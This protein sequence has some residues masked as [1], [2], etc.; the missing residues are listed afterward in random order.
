MIQKLENKA[1]IIS[2]ANFLSMP[3]IRIPEYQRPYKWDEKNVTQLIEDIHFFRHQKGYRFG[4]IV[5]HVNEL[6]ENNQTVVY[7]DIVDGQ[8]RYTTLRLLLYALHQLVNNSNKFQASTLDLISSLK[9][10]LDGIELNYK[11]KSSIENIHRNYQLIKRSIQHFDDDTVFNFIQKFEVVIFYIHDITEAF[12][13][14]DSQN[15]RGKDLFP[16]DLLKAFHLREFDKTE[17]QIQTHIVEHWEK[18]PTKKLSIL[19]AEYLYRIKGWSNNSHARYFSKAQV[20]L[21]KGVSIHKTESYPYV[22]A[23]QIAHHVVDHYNSNFERKIDGQQMNFPFQLDQFIINGRRFFEYVDYY[24][25]INER[26]KSKYLVEKVDVLQYTKEER[27]VNYVYKN[28]Y[29]YRDGENYLRDMFEC[30][31]IYYTDKFGEN[32]LAAFIEKAFV[33]CFYLRFE[34][35]RLGFDS[36]DNYIIANNLFTT[37]KDAMQPKDVLKFTLKKLPTYTD[38]ENFSKQDS[39]RMDKNIVEFFKKN[40]YYAN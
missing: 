29:S 19:F 10:K 5:I 9:N 1:D 38:I 27:I 25:G 34:Y 16:H 28:Q 8:Q 32:E 23:L 30:I 7:N 6:I 4:T 24:L 3:M 2:I 18:Y 40:H 35:Q 39:S 15:S 21:F 17:L 31:M 36:I 33:W 13:F 12:Q 11:T 37:I 26:F 14:F 22:K 20:H